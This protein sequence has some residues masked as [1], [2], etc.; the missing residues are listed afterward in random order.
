MIRYLFLCWLALSPLFVT[1]ATDEAG[2]LLAALDPIV[3]LQGDFR[4]QL[5]D[6]AD[7]LLE[8][9]S[10]RF[11]LLRPGYFAWD[12]QQPDSQLVI[13]DPNYL[14]HYD[15]DLAT[16]TRR[17]VS[18]SAQLSPLQVLGGRDEALREGYVVTSPAAG[19][20]V[21]TPR[22]TQAEFREVGLR[23][24]DGK[25]TG[26]EIRDRLGQRVLIEFSAVDSTT[27]LQPADFQFEPPEGVDLL[28]YD[29]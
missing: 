18:S 3:S 1:A 15:R 19:Q 23:L 17:P 22:D 21:L 28:Y 13:A 26:M 6:D 16:V 29:D 12:I 10:G 4:Q 11:R 5:F 2:E 9:S 20:F 25:L 24:S 27:R 8:E 14:W 7:E